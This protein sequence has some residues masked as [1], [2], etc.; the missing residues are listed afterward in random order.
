MSDKDVEAVAP[1]CGKDGCVE[2]SVIRQGRQFLCPKHYRFGQMRSVARRDGKYVPSHLELEALLNAQPTLGCNDCGRVMNWRSSD[3]AASVLTLQ[4]YRSGS[5]AF[6]CLSCNTRHA[7]MS[8]DSFCDMPTGHKKCPKCD[9]IKPSSEFTKDN[10]RT[11]DIRRKSFCRS[12]SDNL[13]NQWKEAN[14]D[15][16]NAYQRAYRAK[17][18][19][20]GVPVRG[21]R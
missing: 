2:M 16:Y 17:R 3:G 8:G 21:G 9:D 5:L 15:Q 11:G 19:A 13:V 10:S 6:S 1:I 12:C 4:H 14:R 18:K 7:S 20:E